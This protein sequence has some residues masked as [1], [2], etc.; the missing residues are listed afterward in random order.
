MAALVGCSGK[1]TLVPARPNEWERGWDTRRGKD[2]HQG[3]QVEARRVIFSTPCRARSASCRLLPTAQSH[4]GSRTAD[5][6]RAVL[7][8]HVLN[9]FQVP[10]FACI[11]AATLKL[12]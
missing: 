4:H 12:I 7:L 9:N 1:R 10:P 2:P 11:H 8:P 6:F 3:K 5:C